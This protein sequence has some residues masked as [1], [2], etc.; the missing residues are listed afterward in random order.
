MHK[1]KNYLTDSD[2]RFIVNAKLGFYNN[3]TDENI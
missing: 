3:L 1:L 2:Y